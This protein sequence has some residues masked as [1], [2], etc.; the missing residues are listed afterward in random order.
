MTA[1]SKGD[2]RTGWMLLIGT[3]LLCFLVLLGISAGCAATQEDLE[4]L[5]NKLNQ[6][7]AA[8]TQPSA[9]DLLPFGTEIKLASGLVASIGLIFVRKLL[10]DRAAANLAVKQVIAGIE[11]VLPEK[12]ETQKLKLAAAQDESTRK[13]VSDIKGD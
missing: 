1:Y 5:E 2:R 6:T 12:T 3:I 11:E 4:R 8:S 7:N 13:L 9:T 10:K